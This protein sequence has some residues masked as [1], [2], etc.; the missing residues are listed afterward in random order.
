MAPT[1]E[2]IDAA[3]MKCCDRIAEL[4]RGEWVPHHPQYDCRLEAEQDAQAE[5][6][7]AAAAQA[8]AA[9]YAHDHPE[10]IDDYSDAG[11]GL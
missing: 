9:K 4:E 6:D 7:F 11:P 8:Q 5:A 3:R 2:G 10:M 1:T